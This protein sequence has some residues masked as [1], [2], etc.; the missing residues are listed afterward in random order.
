MKNNYSSGATARGRT[1]RTLLMMATVLLL[2]LSLNRA[3]AQYCAAAGGICDEALNNVTFAGIS[4]P[5]PCGSGGYTNWTSL[6]GNVT[7]GSTYP[8][9]CT[10]TLYY[11]GDAAEVWIDWNQNSLFTDAGEYY[12]CTY[13]GS[14]GV[15]T[16]SITVPGTATAGSTRMR[17]R[18]RYNGT[19]NSPCGN[20]GSSFGEV[21][22]Y[23]IAVSGGSAC[24]NPPTAGSANASVSSSCPSTVIGLSLTGNSTGTGQ[25]YQWQ[26]SPDNSTWANISG[27]TATTYGTTQSVAT[28]YRC[29]VTCGTA[30]PSSSVFVGVN[31]FT[32]CYCASAPTNAFDE[33]IY[34]V[35]VNGAVTPAAYANANGCTTPA[36]GPGSVLSLYSNFKSLGAFTSVY[37]TTSV[38][39]SISQNECDGPTYYANGIAIYIDYN[40]NGVFDAS[41]QVFADGVTATGP[42]TVSG[43]FI[44]PGTALTGVTGMRIICAEGY[45]GTGIT[46]CLTYGYGETEDYLID[47]Q[48]APACTEPPVAGTISGSSSLCVGASGSLTLTGYTLGTTIQWQSSPDNATWTN[49][50]GAN[51]SVYA[52]TSF[53]APTYYRAA[54]TCVSTVNSAS[55]FVD[56][57][58]FLNCYCTANLGGS[59]GTQSINSVAIASTT[60]NNPST[61]VFTVP[62]YA[63]Y[64]ASGST[65]A[66][67]LK[68]VPYSMTV[69]TG[70]NGN[71][72]MVGVWIDANQNGLFEATEY[73]QIAASSPSGGT[74][75]AIITVPATALTG[76]TGMRVRSNWASNP[77]TGTDACSFFS[78]GET[79]DYIITIDPAPVCT[80]PP[81]AGSITGSSSLCIGA[82]AQL[83]LTGYSLGTTLQ[84]QS[85]A[86]N[87]TF[88]NISGETNPI[89]NITSFATPLYYRVEVTCANSTLTSSFQVTQAPFYS[90]YCIPTNAGSGCMTNVT[91]N[92]LNNTTPGCPGGTNYASFPAT[93]TVLQGVTYPLS[94]TLDGTGAAIG[95]IWIDYDHN[96]IYDASEWVQIGTNMTASAT[97]TINIQIPL[98]ALTGTTGMRI[99]TRLNGNQNGAGDACLAM[100]SGETEDYTITIDPPP[101]C[102][103]PP[104]AGTISGT[105]QFCS[106]N[107]TLL[108][109]TGY[110]LGSA[111]QWQTSPDNATWSNISGAINPTYSTSAFAYYRAV[112]TCVSSSFSASVQ[113]TA[114]PFSVCY[115]SAI[116]SQ[117]G[118]E[119]I[120]GVTLNGATNSSSCLTTGG[121]G[122]ILN[123]YSNYT[124]LGT[125]FTVQRQVTYPVS[126]DVGTCGGI[127]T[128]GT[129][130][131][132]DYNQNGSYA[133]PGEQVYGTAVGTSGPHIVN[134]SFLVPAG[135]T[136]GV[137]GMRVINAEGFTAATI[138]PCLVY[139]YGETEDYLIEIQAAPTCVDPPVGGTATAA[140]TSVCSGSGTTLGLTGQT[141]GTTYQWQESSDDINYTDIS[142]A[143]NALYVTAG[144]TAS[145][146]F[147]CAVSCVSTTN[148]ASIL[149]S[150]VPCVNQ[151]ASGTAS[152]TTCSANYY[153]SGGPANTY[154]V[155]ET[156]VFTVCPNPGNQLKVVFSVFNTETNWDP[157]YIYDGPTT[158][159]PLFASTNGTS[160]GGF[161][162]GGWWGTTIP[163]GAG[164]FTSTDPSGC[165]TFE[166]LSD[167]SVTNPGWQAV[168]SCISNDCS[169]QPVITGISQ[170][171]VNCPGTATLLE[172]SAGS[173]GGNGI[174]YL[175]EE[176]DDDGVL[177]PWAPASGTNSNR[178]YVTPT[179][180]SGMYYRQSMSCSFSGLS[181]TSSSYQ[182]Q[183]LPE[184]IVNAG[185]NSPVCASNTIFLT[186]SNDA[187]GQT[188][189]SYL[190]D[191]PA[192]FNDVTQNPQIPGVTT[193][194]S[195]S[196]EVT[197]T[198]NFGC[199]A[200]N[201][202]VVNVN[203]NPSLS[204]LNSTP[205]T[206]NGGADGA[207]TVEA[208]NGAPTYL[209]TNGIDI[210]ID[211]VFTGMVAGSYV[212]NVTDDNGCSSELSVNVTEPDPTTTAAAGSDQ[213]LCASSSA[214]LAGNNA[215][216][217]VGT[218][219]LESGTG[220]ITDPSD[221]ASGVTGLGIGTNVF[222]WTIDNAACFNSNFD[223]VTIVNNPLPTASISG[224]NT[225]CT[226]GSTSLT[227]VFTGTAPYTYSYSNGVTTFGPFTT[228][229]NPENIVVSPA[230]TKTYSMVTV[231]DNNCSGTVSGSAVVT[232]DQAP[233]ANSVT[234]TTLPTT[235]CVGNTVTV[236]TNAVIFATNYT[237]S[238]PAGTLINGQPSP[239]TTTV[240]TATLTLGP[241]PSNASGWEICAQAS[242][243]CG[244]TNT[245]CKY[246]RGALSLPSAITGTNF[247]CASTSASYSILPVTGASGYTWTGT[248]GIT[249]TGTGTSVTANFPS[250]F[251]TGQICVA[252]NLACG[253]QGPSRC[254]TVNNSIAQLGI[255]SGPFAVCPGQTGLVFSVPSA[256]GAA[257][258]NWTPPSG[259]TIT[260]GAGTN[261]VT[262]SV[263]PG[264]TVGNL[265]VTATSACGVTSA[266][267]CKTISST[268]P[269]TPGNV[270]GT[271]TGICGQ[272]VTFSVPS[273]SG[274]TSYNWSTPAGATLVSANGL[275]SVD[276]SFT[277]GF[278][279]GQLCVTASNGCGTSSARCINVK[280][281]PASPGLITGPTTVCNSEQ[282]IFFSIPPVFGATTYLWTVPAGAT[283]VAGQ[284]STSIIVDWGLVSGLVT[285]SA[286]NSCG[287][288]GTRTLNVIVNCKVSGNSLPGTAVSA[289]P[290]PVATELTVELD[291]QNSGTYALE[292]LDLSGRVVL[293]DNIHAVAGMNRT[294]VDVSTLAKGMYMLSIRNSEGF[295]QQIR[296]AVE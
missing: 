138:T 254:M 69:G 202:V 61:C 111:I 296:I 112:V 20:S 141:L 84:W 212:V 59:C 19:G 203:N 208:T 83:T 281:A 240:P 199:T 40:Q 233:P 27:A 265:C 292:M 52:I 39:F 147:R 96:G 136:L 93:T 28:Y 293:A 176:S 12:S 101:P 123:R 230:T 51:L 64:P 117:T 285:V 113:T 126:V 86:D 75:T 177:D 270:S 45:S 224:T 127:F 53:A 162:A 54:V 243:A 89:Y 15:F 264:F 132:I 276:V 57:S 263:A 157:L 193:A 6:T 282:G 168:F 99:R 115:C 76:Q 246:I 68:T 77:F 121:P 189:T 255:M 49:I 88:T 167:G 210:N 159:S 228:S 131:F 5:S 275:S 214:T 35:N 245:Q 286:S 41:E 205:V 170:P 169:G 156:G 161:P 91:F 231:D 215:L 13:T 22:D 259:V 73:T 7:I 4:N 43:S 154:S 78:F 137:T 30:V 187:P 163:G 66:T 165:L 118:D 135:A 219:T 98:T 50:P 14:G 70:N 97:T 201:S 11:G 25:T 10:T 179:L 182:V 227:V 103:E 249:F 72:A 207:F 95:S 119:E 250:G 171:S 248:N 242:N 269:G 109:L 48:P 155:S 284:N 174:T 80:D 244:V 172:P 277:A 71:P 190:W 253:Y 238:A 217:G 196:Y 283:I 291:A 150:V 200:S 29:E 191:G 128:S 181:A 160:S 173:S 100:G 288:S 295:T 268:L 237:W 218:W 175:W 247:A 234:I 267:R 44:V 280:G 198:N 158:A 261:S 153:D 164:G 104:S 266:A 9:S 24:V 81:L 149:I 183:F 1:L 16:T 34:E 142:G 194:Y 120:F 18:M 256:N 213:S 192:G 114:N 232:V 289:Y 239:V 178:T 197:I 47:V 262:V 184:P 229:N 67:L 58:A 31:P 74:S 107:S 166:F 274:I 124:N 220:T 287:N 130:V 260:S 272:T 55:W 225:I 209:Y 257:T 38:P 206:C 129:A 56:Q 188:A 185:S 241:I 17:V 279:T 151:P 106:G 271:S 60:L 92:T 102:T 251:T 195:G 294:S 258:Y 65:T 273:V 37:K 134:G 226:G 108:T 148:S 180:S 42:R 62:V 125:F 252:A 143:T 235:G 152:L 46:G 32:D 236:A 278:T 146:Y 94:V 105:L 145:T 63:S 23:T 133:D 122:S 2:S 21:E 82:S 116:P 85:S 216:V 211:G 33:E 144:L 222:R 290:N 223:E 110:D 140:I 90:C 87:I 139:G 26:S 3:Q 36:P 79:E 204:V 221:P 186:S 8:F